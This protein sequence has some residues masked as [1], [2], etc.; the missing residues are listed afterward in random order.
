MVILVMIV[1]SLIGLMYFLWVFILRPET[2]KME[3]QS[4]AFMDYVQER[5]LG[6]EVEEDARSYLNRLDEQE[7]EALHD[8]YAEWPEWVTEVNNRLW[9]RIYP[10]RRFLW[11]V[12]LIS[13][14]VAAAIVV[15]LSI[16]HI[17]SESVWEGMLIVLSVFVIPWFIS[18]GSV[19]VADR[20]WRRSRARMKVK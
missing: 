9:D 16:K 11:P 13:Y 19:D 18:T 20:L 12:V 3:A 1:G 4:E 5:K 15:P 10:K 14:V 7:L 2:A 8:E 6:K 17:E